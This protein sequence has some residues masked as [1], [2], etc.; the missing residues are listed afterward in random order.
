MKYSFCSITYGSGGSWVPAYTLEETIKRVAGIK[1]DGLGVVTA[2]PHAW[3]YH[4]D[5][6]K[7]NYFLEE[8]KKHNLAVSSIIPFMAGGPGYNVATQN[9][10]ERRWTIEYLKECARLAKAWNSDSITYLPGWLLYGDDKK[11]AWKNSVNS[12]KEVA[13]FAKE[14]GISVLIQQPLS[15][16][17]VVDS[18]EDARY[19]LAETNMDNVGLMFD[20]ISAVNRKQ[21]PA[22]YVYMMGKD[23]KAIH[24]CDFDRK[25]PGTAG[26]DFK[27][28]YL[29]LQEIG[30]DGY[31]TVEV[32]ASRSTNADSIARK[33]LE[34]LKELENSI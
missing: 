13:A 26:L 6:A 17:N 31:I 28:L 34:Y 27:Q 21:D 30:Y 5:N 23:L 20:V 8:F 18:P 10:K 9:E 15:Q 33:S 29:A 7:R 19:M 16:T 4:L 22:D 1:Y 12:L 32:E 3:P 14:I 25:Q 11:T 24:V 2:S